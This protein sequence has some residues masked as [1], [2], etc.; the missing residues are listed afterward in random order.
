MSGY[1]FLAAEQAAHQQ[2]RAELAAQKEAHRGTREELESWKRRHD[3]ALNASGTGGSNPA[4][5]RPNI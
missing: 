4:P 3:A 2:T 5:L 1:W